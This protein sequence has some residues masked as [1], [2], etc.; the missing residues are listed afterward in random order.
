MSVLSRKAARYII[1]SIRED[2]GGISQ[3]DRKKTPPAVLKALESVRAKL[4]A[5]TKT[6]HFPTHVKLEAHRSQS[7][8]EY[9]FKR[10]P[11]CL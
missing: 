5:S 11:L 1:D 3:A 6:Y 2:N 9:L 8:H 4:G 7:C 10:H